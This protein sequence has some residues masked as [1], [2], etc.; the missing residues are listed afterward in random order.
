[1]PPELHQDDQLDG[2]PFGTR[3]GTLRSATRSRGTATTASA[4]QLTR[5]AGASFDDI[6]AFDKPQRLELSIDGEPVHVFEL[7]GPGAA[8]RRR[9]RTRRTEIAA[10]ST[11]TGTVRVP[12][13]GGSAD[14]RAH[15][16]QSDAGA[17]REPARAVPEAGVRRT[18]RLLHD[19]EG[20]VSPYRRDQ[21]AVRRP[22]A[23]DTP[24]RQRIFVLHGLREAADEDACAKKILAHAGAPRVPAAGRRRRSRDSLCVSTTKAAPSGGF[25]A[26][27]ERAVEGLLVSPEF[28]FRVEREP[29]DS[30]SI[31]GR[32]PIRISDLEL[33]SRLSFFLWSSIPDDELLDWRAGKLRNP[34]VLE[35]QVRRMLADPRAERS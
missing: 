26:G 31:G 1:M 5:D 3:G 21:R 35:Q 23:G 22:G 6:P 7:H 30:A 28:L 12:G 10:R 33:A 24:S 9:R 14:G 2:L 13:E 32:S 16:P 27:I 34:G 4:S 11:P 29:A 20:R 8:E 19:A 18:E 15:V 25:E 17:A